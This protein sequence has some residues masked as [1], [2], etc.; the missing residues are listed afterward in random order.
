MARRVLS[1]NS[2]MTRYPEQAVSEEPLSV[3]TATG[4]SFPLGAT[5]LSG[6]A[7]FSIFSRSATRI[8][9]LFFD[10]VDD[11]N[12][13]RII[14]IDPCTNR[15]VPLLA[16]VRP[17]RTSGSDSTDSGPTG[18]SSRTRGLRFDPSKLLLD[19]YGRAI[20]VPKNYSRDAARL[21][22]RQHRNGH[23]KRGYGPAGV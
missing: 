20:V 15:Y 10:H 9:L 19:P 1:R 3:V 13:S 22:R 14:P 5:L 8:E 21:E 18:R 11:A 6:G 12:P 2:T 7:N 16:R 23:E 4:R 17:R